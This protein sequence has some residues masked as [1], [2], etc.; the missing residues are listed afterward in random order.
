MR[1]TELVI[2]LR[3]DSEVEQVNV[4]APDGSRVRSL[5]VVTGETRLT[6]EL[7][8][9]Y[10]PGTYEVTTEGG[11]GASITL[12]PDLVIE[13]LGVGA[14]NPDV[15][16]DSLGNFEP[17]AATVLVRNIGSGPTAVQNLA[18][19]G[20]IPNE[21]EEVLE[22]AETSGIFD[23]GTGAGEVEQV[24]IEPNATAR[25]FSS[26]LPF[27][28]AGEQET[29]SSMPGDSVAT[30]K[31]EDTARSVIFETRYE[32]SYRPTSDDD[33]EITVEGEVN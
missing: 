17:F 8:V 32:L 20:D 26:T 21:T 5:S 3:E 9:R 2:E 6:V 4:I 22:S 24:L 33:C 19:L 27:S 10:V 25:L 29:C 18:F 12:E 1:G 30:V 28:F 7:G 14:N 23:T 13:E 15:M 31:I 11:S 16:P